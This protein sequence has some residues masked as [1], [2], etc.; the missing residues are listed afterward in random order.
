[1]VV[2]SGACAVRIGDSAKA[3]RLRIIGRA[4][5]RSVRLHCWQQLGIKRPASPGASS[6]STDQILLNTIVVTPDCW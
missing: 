2:Q 3:T 5:G 4:C 6:P 1:M